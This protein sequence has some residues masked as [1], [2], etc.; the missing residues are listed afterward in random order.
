MSTIHAISVS[1]TIHYWYECQFVGGF[2]LQMLTKG[3][4]PCTT[5]GALI[6]VGGPLVVLVHH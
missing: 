1:V 2:L 4:N 5:I 6:S 3:P